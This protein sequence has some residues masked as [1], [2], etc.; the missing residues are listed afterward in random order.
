LAPPNPRSADL[1]EADLRGANLRDAD[2][3]R[4]N[5]SGAHERLYWQ[6]RRPISIEQLEQARSLEGATMPNGQKDEDWLKDK[7]RE[8]DG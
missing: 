3:S 5:L 2:L 1:G 6:R 7:G 4:A 8:S